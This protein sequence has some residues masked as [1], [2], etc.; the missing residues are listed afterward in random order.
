MAKATIAKW[1]QKALWSL[2]VLL[3]LGLPI[4]SFSHFPPALGGNAQVRPFSLY[5]LV[6]L[7]FVVALPA[8]FRRRLSAAALWLFVFTA[9]AVVASSLFVL[10][11]IA[12]VNGVHPPARVV[13]ALLTLAIG[14]AFYFT[15][16]F[17]PRTKEQLASTLRWL[18][19]ALAWSLAWGTF[20]IGYILTHSYSW[21]LAANHLQRLISTRN[22]LTRRISGPAYEPNWFAS[23][24]ALVFMPWLVASV[25]TGKSVFKIRWRWL[26]VEALLTVWAFGVLL[27][28]YS[29]A[30][31]ATGLLVLFLGLVLHPSRRLSFGKRAL[32][33]GGLAALA[34]AALF[35]LGKTNSYFARIWTYWGL[36]LEKY[37]YFLGMKGRFAYW[38]AAYITYL[39][40]P[41]LG[42]GLG[43]F[44]FYFAKN[45]TPQPL[46][47]DHE[48]LKALL[49]GSGYG[50][51]TPKNMYV[52]ILAETGL[53][54][55]VTF[56]AYWLASLRDGLRMFVAA[57]PEARFWGFGA[58]LGF[59]AL[60]IDAVS[61]GS[62]AVADLWVFLGL[63][64][65]AGNVFLRDGG[66]GD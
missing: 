7:A 24:I 35:L 53:L 29:R 54:G 32:I 16:A 38:K 62:F 63:I 60:L 57:H 4:S 13:R 10:R 8:L 25:L 2:W 47:I 27:F 45:V 14:A 3:L 1:W 51:A 17:M 44:G 6:V 5:P 41:F 48:L 56:F 9:V 61:F 43:N 42:V 40:H 59:A 21:Y 39:Q 46:G 31:L 58:L 22:L 55:F 12:P 19:A 18:Y 15:V 33:G 50:I 49:P 26:T 65:A 20:Q 64:A 11:D 28:T 37:I 34:A 30:G 23:Q 66:I 36:P 52:R